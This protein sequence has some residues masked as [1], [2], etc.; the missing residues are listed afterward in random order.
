M[1]IEDEDIESIITID[2]KMIASKP[3]RMYITK[4]H[5]IFGTDIVDRDKVT[6]I[7]RITDDRWD[8][9]G[10]SIILTNTIAGAILAYS[11]MVGIVFSVLITLLSG[12]L[13]YFILRLVRENPYAYISLETENE[14]YQFGVLTPVDMAE[15]FGAVYQNLDKEMTYESMKQK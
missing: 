2:S 4:E 10:L 14:E 13:G 11:L 5:L 7:N 8:K 1:D 15:L 3:S 6:D 12:L 9:I